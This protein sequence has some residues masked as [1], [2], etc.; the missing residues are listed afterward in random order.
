[1]KLIVLS[2]D[3]GCADY[4]LFSLE[5]PFG[6]FCFRWDKRLEFSL[7]NSEECILGFHI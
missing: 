7:F 6:G 5:F 1:M 3:P 4:C 2:Y